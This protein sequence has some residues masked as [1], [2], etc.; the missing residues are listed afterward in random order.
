[1]Y[2][3][4]I[5]TQM[6]RNKSV[7]SESLTANVDKTGTFN[8]H[9]SKQVLKLLDSINIKI[10]SEL[11][12]NPNINSLTLS[13]KLGIPLS[14]IQRRRARIEKV[15]LMRNYTFNYKAFGGRIGDLIVSVDKG[16][17]KEVAQSVLRKYKNNV[18]LCDT[19]INSMHNISVRVIYKSTEEL[20]ELIESIKTMDYVN[21]LQW[22]EV[23]EVI[24]E[25]NSEV[26]RAFF[27]TSS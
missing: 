3:H 7:R 27:N 26:I 5:I 8:N 19:R 9:S 15:I 12:K 25:N 24:G 10:I 6:A 23:V 22:S 21:A 11:V 18:A 1:M 17:S 16:K 13:K 4:F 14:T 2:F 20:Y